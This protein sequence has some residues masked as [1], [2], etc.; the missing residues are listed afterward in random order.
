MCQ[1]FLQLN[2]DKT[3]VIV[4]GAKEERL[5]VSTQLQSVMLKA[6]D[7]ARNLGVVMD[8]DLNL[9]NHIKTTTKSAYYHLKN[10]SRIKTLLS[11]QEKFAHAFIFSKLDYC[12]G[13]F[14]GLPEV[15]Q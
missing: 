3:E 8:S 2:K 1:N 5:R 10:I 15:H 9:N 13:V 4:F 12:N 6:T 14:T 7:Q 11:Q